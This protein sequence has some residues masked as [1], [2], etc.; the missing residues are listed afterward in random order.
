MGYVSLKIV[1]EP[2]FHKYEAE[3]AAKQVAQSIQPPGRFLFGNSKVAWSPEDVR[4]K[5]CHDLLVQG[6]KVPFDFCGHD[7][8]GVCRWSELW[9]DRKV[10]FEFIAPE[11]EGCSADRFYFQGGV[12][13]TSDRVYFPHEDINH[14]E[15]W[16]WHLSDPWNDTQI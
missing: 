10:I 16:K 6:L 4:E 12:E 7:W 8:R 5:R 14:P 9:P 3:H 1:V 2:P 13:V 11:W 15:R